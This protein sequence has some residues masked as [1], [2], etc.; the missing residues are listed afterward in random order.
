MDV[1]FNRVF[2]N[3]YLKN[4]IYTF[5]K[6]NNKEQRYIRYN[7]YDFPFELVFKTK[8]QHLLIEKL[9]HYKFHFIENSNNNNSHN[10]NNNNNNHH[11]NID[12]FKFF[13]IFNKRCLEQLYIWKELPL[14]LFELVF[15][16]FKNEIREIKKNY[17]IHH[18]HPTI[19][20]QSKKT[21]FFSIENCNL[22][23]LKFLIFNNQIELNEINLSSLN[24][25]FQDNNKEKNSNLEEGHY[26]IEK[27]KEMFRYLYD[28]LKI[29]FGQLA[30]YLE[31]IIDN[32][33]SEIY[34]PM[35]LEYFPKQLD[36]TKKPLESCFV[37]I[38]K[39][40]D[41]FILKE[42]LNKYKY[43]E[44]PSICQDCLLQTPI[45]LIN[46]FGI[47]VDVLVLRAMSI[48]LRCLFE[49][50]D[51]EITKVLWENLNFSGVALIRERS[52]STIYDP[53][54]ALYLS[55]KLKGNTHKTITLTCDYR[56]KI[57]GK[58]DQVS[59]QTENWQDQH[60]P[61][62]ANY[63]SNNI[64]KEMI[65][66]ISTTQ[67]GDS[68][69]LLDHIIKK[70]CLDSLKTYLKKFPNNYNLEQIKTVSLLREGGKDYLQCFLDII[71]FGQLPR[72]PDYTNSFHLHFLRLLL[73]FSIENNIG[74]LFDAVA[75]RLTTQF[76][77]N[78]REIQQFECSGVSDWVVS[79]PSIARRW[80]NNS[81]LKP[82]YKKIVSD[83]VNQLLARSNHQITQKSLVES[84]FLFGELSNIDVEI[85][86]P[87]LK[88]NV[89]RANIIYHAVRNEIV[90]TNY[91]INING[92]SNQ[93]TL[94]S[95]Y[96]GK[97]FS[98]LK[99][100]YDSLDIEHGN[101]FFMY[102]VI[103]KLL[104]S[105]ILSLE[106][107][108]SSKMLSKM[109][110]LQEKMLNFISTFKPNRNNIITFHKDFKNLN[111]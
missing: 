70:G 32:N 79:N 40:Q 54:V 89:F 5:I 59:F 33:L 28:V 93:N 56:L 107:L 81:L 69:S 13:L 36:F 90:L 53:N 47:S 25:L 45:K 62:E 68:T 88:T 60:S 74:M 98:N 78:Q 16:M 64:S 8:N 41:I 102:K 77:T 75:Y 99:H 104:E 55:E 100:N 37:S 84:K 19:K 29:P 52:F 7:Y 39:R 22:E 83:M 94:K 17:E 97:F 26:E 87:S 11:N 30:N 109:P 31:F 106:E 80:L 24:L 3:K 71:K 96:R 92:L 73:E 18:I 57:M 76:L 110:K 63:L 58:R 86:L 48:P 10:N 6:E 34:G 65:E 101:G 66:K 103:T 44:Q 9:N 35:I 67:Y 111:F 50:F 20:I 61:F 1:L 21:N 23:R 38:I 82:Y 2:K 85:R 4:K 95:L 43:I 15:N 46:L 72:I 105:N 91:Q 42:I 14:E 49:S 27:R 108:E 12:K 51:V